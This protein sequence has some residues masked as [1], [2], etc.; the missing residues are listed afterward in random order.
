[1]KVENPK[2]IGLLAGEV[3]R[4]L[5]DNGPSTMNK[6]KKELKLGTGQVE[7]GVGWLARRGQ[8]QLFSRIGESIL[9]AVRGDSK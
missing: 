8:A 6:M 1:M 4:Y 5:Y 3:Y 2:D 9:L 7:Q